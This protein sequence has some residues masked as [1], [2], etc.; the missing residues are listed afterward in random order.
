V[1]SVRIYLQ[2]RCYVPWRARV[3]QITWHQKVSGQCSDG[4]ENLYKSLVLILICVYWS[5]LRLQ[6][7]EECASMLGVFTNL[8]KTIRKIIPNR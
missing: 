1:G 7:V 2:R 8:E 5:L 4:R 3:P 6:T